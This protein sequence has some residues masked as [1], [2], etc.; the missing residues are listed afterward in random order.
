MIYI[1]YIVYSFLGSH[2]WHMEVPMPEVELEP[3]L[4]A[5]A[6]AT[7]TWDPSCIGNLYHSSLLCWILKQ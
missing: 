6:T 2:L 7:A 4:L 3:Q 1:L 5:Y